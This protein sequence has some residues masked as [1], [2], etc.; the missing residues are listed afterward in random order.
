MA[1]FNVSQTKKDFPIFTNNPGL[2]YLDS[3]ASG[4]R[5]QSVIAAM[6][7]YYTKYSSNIHR[8]LYPIA[9]KASQEY[10]ETREVIAQFIGATSAN[11]IIFTRNATESL[12]LLAYCLQSEIKSDDEI[13]TSII[14]H[15]ANFVTWQQLALK[16]GAKFSII[17]VDSRGDLN[18]F[19]KDGAISLHK[20]VKKNR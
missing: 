17:D 3:A 7:D 8:G 18:I 16:T 12:N 10:E 1:M 4:L 19:D 6:N 5:P 15:H 11:E 9:E 13:V 2:V 14:E 20:Y